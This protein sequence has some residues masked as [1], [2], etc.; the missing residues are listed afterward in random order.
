MENFIDLDSNTNKYSKEQINQAFK[1]KAS[2]E[3]NVVT[4]LKNSSYKKNKKFILK[5]ILT[6]FLF[7]F[8]NILIMYLLFKKNKCLE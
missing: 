4:H 6:M 3:K 1:N 5:V 7:A 8:F 2:N